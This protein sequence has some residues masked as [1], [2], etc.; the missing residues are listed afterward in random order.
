MG[1]PQMWPPVKKLSPIC[2]IKPVKYSCV[3]GEDS[4]LGHSLR[5]LPSMP[6]IYSR[7]PTFTPS[8]NRRCCGMRA[9]QERR[10]RPHRPRR[11][12]GR[13]GGSGGV[14]PAQA[15]VAEPVHREDHSQPKD[16]RGDRRCGVLY[17]LQNKLIDRD[18][19]P[20]PDHGRLYRG[21]LHGLCDQEGARQFAVY[22]HLW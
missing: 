8:P 10:C 4:R 9:R 18:W 3:E 1:R 12:H 16:A 17:W 13:S 22:A 14:H 7:L 15:S 11:H 6:A 2:P 19:R 5:L 20:V 21:L